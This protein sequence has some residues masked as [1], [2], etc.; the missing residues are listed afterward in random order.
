MARVLDGTRVI[1]LGTFITGPCVGMMLA[2]LGAD[3]VKIEQP[4]S[5]D[6]FRNYRGEL[7]SPQFRAFNARKRSLTLNL[8]DSRAVEVLNRL[9]READVLIENYR[10][11]VLDNLGF[12]WPQF[13]A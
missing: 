8:K 12:G 7:Y 5:G 1:E 9:A 13:R 10:P 2:N 4:G 11:G 3:V 6:P